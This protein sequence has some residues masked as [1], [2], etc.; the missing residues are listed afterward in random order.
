MRAFSKA[1]ISEDPK[2][3]VEFFKS[4]GFIHIKGFF[5]QQM[6]ESC[7]DAIV[8]LESDVGAS[9][10]VSVVT[11]HIN[12]KDMVKYYQGVYSQS[13]VFRKFFSLELLSL[14]GLLLEKD[15]VYFADIEAHL[16][17]P[18]GGEIPK[19]QDN[20]YFNLSNSSGVTAYIAMTPHDKDSGGL[21]YRAKSHER[22]RNHDASSVAGFSSYI[23]E[24]GVAGTKA[25]IYAPRYEV[26]DISIHHANNIHWSDACPKSAQ[27]GY[28]LSARIFDIDA[29][30][31]QS[32]VER[33]HRLLGL[34]RS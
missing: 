23:R 29:E 7:V 13:K 27:R 6:C 28:A 12:G 21:N 11:E 24:E 16:R 18:G 20:F 22:V 15:S 10:T 26:G 30:I 3:V 1:E 34:N 4:Y 19:H 33:Y 2:R 31:D 5:P 25:E 9:N 32:G 14:G 17:N 8:E